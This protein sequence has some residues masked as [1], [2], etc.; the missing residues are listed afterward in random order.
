MI[1]KFTLFEPFADELIHGVTTKPLGSFNEEDEVFEKQKKK[2]PV[3]PIFSRQMHGDKI[4]K[5]TGKPD[6][7]F[8]GDAFITRQINLPLAVKIADCQ[9]ILMYDPKT[10]SIAAVHA[11]WRSSAQNIIGKTIKEM[12]KEFGTNPADLIVG[13]SPSLG[14]CCAT[15]S[16]PEKE[17][18]EFIHPFIKGRNVNFW[19]LSLQQLKEAGVPE[20]QIEIAKECTKCNPNRYFSHRN[21]DTG[22]IAVFIGLKK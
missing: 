21:A 18:P 22:R 3:D 10:D 2:L 19:S 12:I 17:L 11:G 7:Q 4:I 5:V 14:P 9:G 6:K 8:E 20:N 13:V 16:D 15:F 1:L